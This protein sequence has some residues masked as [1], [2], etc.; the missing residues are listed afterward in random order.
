M[1]YAFERGVLLAVL[2]ISGAGAA[3][4]RA[5]DT[6]VWT[7]QLIY[8]ADVTGALQGGVQRAGRVL[9]NIDLILDGDLGQALGWGDTK[10]HA[11]VL[12]NSGG[13]PNDVAGSLQGVD[14]IEVAQPRLRLYEAWVEHG[15]GGAS[16]LA[17]LYNLNSEF[18]T[19]E[20]SG[21]LIAPPFGI[22][23]ELASTGPN[24]P[25]IFPLTALAVRVKGGGD[26]GLYG[27]A[28]VLSAHAGAFGQTDELQ[29]G[30]DRGALVIGE[31]GWRG[32]GRIAVGAWGYSERQDDIREVGPDGAPARRAA[33][34][35][36]LLAE[37]PLRSFANGAALAGFLR[38]GASD[39]DTSPYV[40]GW[41]AGLRLE[42]F[43]PGRPQAA[44]SVGVQQG[45]LSRKQRANG[46]DE[47]RDIG[48]DESGVE[49]VYADTVGRVSV[50]PDLQFIRH[51][52]GDQGRATAVVGALRLIID[53]N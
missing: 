47:G 30:M 49:I 40:G 29:L 43:V 27:E 26:K 7:H 36:Y 5:A 38:A 24:G 32:A 17:G 15:F 21:L 41:Q 31:T 13:H 2:V 3:P 22:G 33:H 23:S 8:T 18:Y 44:F 50:R 11:Y 34:G 12:N 1:L 48:P 52:Q 51:P 46:A 14:N 39:G 42:R 10:A 53:L 35:A 20:T 9:D 6:P 25:S 4:A 19:T 28:A 16:V 45:L 37:G